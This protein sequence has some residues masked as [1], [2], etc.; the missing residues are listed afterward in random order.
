[1]PAPPK[2]DGDP[3]VDPFFVFRLENIDHGT[4]LGTLS[5]RT[6]DKK[7]YALGANAAFER[8]TF[9]ATASTMHGYALVDVNG[10][11]GRFVRFETDGSIEELGRGTLRGLGDILLDFDGH[12]GTFALP[13]NDHLDNV[14]SGVFP[15]RF[16]F[17]D[18]K[19]RWTALLHEYDGTTASLSI[20]ESALDFYAAARSPGPP[21]VLTPTARR[22]VPDWR[23]TFISSLPGIA[24]LT[25][26]EPTPD[27]GR[28]EYRNLQLE[29]TATV[30]AGVS[31]YVSTPEGLIYAV[32]FGSSAGIW[33]VRAR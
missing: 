30:S 20:T 31:D 1:M 8:L 10:S 28:L 15:G 11:T 23:T 26:Y 25:D 19:D 5:M 17:R 22:V 33:A 13:S 29:F 14:A 32:P 7:D 4:G 3:A 21:P 24:Y 27:I 9:V 6:P 12:V 2:L 18:S 16:R